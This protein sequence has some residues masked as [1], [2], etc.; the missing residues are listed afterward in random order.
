MKS[1][2]TR[3]SR[4]FSKGNVYCDKTMQGIFLYRNHGPQKFLTQKVTPKHGSPDGFSQPFLVPTLDRC[5]ELK[6]RKE[7]YPM[8]LPFTVPYPRASQRGSDA[9][10][11]DPSSV[12]TCSLSDSF[13]L[14]R[15]AA[16]EEREWKERRKHPKGKGNFTSEQRQT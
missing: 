14:R 4:R 13:M 6:H 3:G 9:L 11:P 15:G 5:Y 1:L 8:P 12:L 2:Q 7:V 16:G 10:S